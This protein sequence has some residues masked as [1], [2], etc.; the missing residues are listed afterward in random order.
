MEGI[1][2]TGLLR[3]SLVHF[4]DIPWWMS[5]LVCYVHVQDCAGVRPHCLVSMSA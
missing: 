3:K 2:R 5:L 4:L 1:E